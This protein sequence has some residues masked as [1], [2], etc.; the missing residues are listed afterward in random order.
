VIE[1]IESLVPPIIAPVIE[2]PPL[3][4]P[5]PAPAPQA[6]PVITNPDWLDRPSGAEIS[7]YYPD[8]AARLGVEGRALINCRVSAQ[9]RLE[10]CV[11]AHE[12]PADQ[13]FGQAAMQM[14]RHFKMRPMTRD[15]VAVAGGTISI[16][17]RFTL[18]A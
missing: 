4:E 12:S 17:I 6:P 14:S 11:V 8:R 1:R 15:G 13:D 5:A 10:A 16:P 18:P 3:P 2:P 7:R 9:G